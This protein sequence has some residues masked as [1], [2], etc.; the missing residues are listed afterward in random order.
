MTK[1]YLKYFIEFN[2][3]GKWKYVG[4]RF[5]KSEAIYLAKSIKKDTGY[6]VRVRKES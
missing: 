6:A 5:S 2:E 4:I 3:G 1:K